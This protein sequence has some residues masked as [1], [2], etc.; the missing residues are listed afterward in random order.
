[1]FSLSFSLLIICGGLLSS[2]TLLGVH[3]SYSSSRRSNL[4]FD[5]SLSLAVL[6]GYFNDFLFIIGFQELD[7][8]GEFLFEVS[9]ASWIHELMVFIIC[10]KFL[11]LFS[12]F[13]PLVLQL[14]HYCQLLNPTLQLTFLKPF[15]I[16]LPLLSNF[17]LTCF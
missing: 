13:S 15:L 9:S 5:F 11:A 16:S 10:G 14:Q 12:L 4:G 3:R 17:L 1:M 7:H 6:S 8:P 2:L